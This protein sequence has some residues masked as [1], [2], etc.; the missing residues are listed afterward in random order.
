MCFDISLQEIFLQ[1]VE[2]LSTTTKSKKIEV[3]G[4]FYSESDMKTELGYS[5][6][7]SCTKTKSHAHPLEMISLQ[8]SLMDL[9]SL[10][11]QGANRQDQEVGHCEALGE[12]TKYRMYRTTLFPCMAS[13]HIDIRIEDTH[14]LPS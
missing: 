7:S 13:M 12:E 10:A 2:I 11:T 14:V 3:H 9:D 6:F 4:G 1:R 8:P 5:P